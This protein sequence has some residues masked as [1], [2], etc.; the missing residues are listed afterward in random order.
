MEMCPISADEFEKGKSATKKDLTEV[1]E[2]GKGYTTKEV[3]DLIGRSWGIAKNI[4][5]AAADE[6]TIEVKK[7]GRSIYWRLKPQ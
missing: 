2:E 3:A 6:G 5:K 7:V 1:L 4:L